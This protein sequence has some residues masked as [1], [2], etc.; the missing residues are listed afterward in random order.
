MTLLVCSD[1]LI[2]DFLSTLPVMAELAKHDELH[3][4]IHP[5]AE[6]IF[7][8][9]PKKYNIKLQEKESALYDRI[10]ELNISKAFDIA[11]DHN[12]YMSQSHFAYLSLPV[13]QQPP[14]AELEFDLAD[15]AVY[16]YIVAPFSRSLPPE[17]R[18]P[19]AQWQR[20][21]DLMPDHTFCIIGHD[22]DERDFVTG[23]NV[24][25]MYNEPLLKVINILKNAGKGLISV[26][27]G[28]SHLAFHLC[29]KNYLLTNQNMT[30]GINPEAVCV[31]DYIPDLKA[32]RLIEVLNLD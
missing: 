2:G 9:I 1:G 19:K 11:N 22:R 30:W 18:W 10:L 12:Y 7:H 25:H 13:P 29:V 4:N 24:F 23:N 26:V 3:L 31:C 17:Q 6:S 15:G 5:E 16:D 21:A 20:L 8:L 32:E 28:P 27:S 14:K